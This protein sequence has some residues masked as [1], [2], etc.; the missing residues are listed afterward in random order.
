MIERKKKPWMHEILKGKNGVI[1][2]EEKALQGFAF[3]H[4]ADR[5]R[6]VTTGNKI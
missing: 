4:E 6:S 3:V 2:D 5:P 1:V